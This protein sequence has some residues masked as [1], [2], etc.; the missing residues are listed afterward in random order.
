MVVTGA[1]MF[2]R[3]LRI[4]LFAAVAI[5]VF[6][7][8]GCQSSPGTAASSANN[9][10]VN[11]SNSNA[12]ADTAKTDAEEI[13]RLLDEYNTALLARDSETLARIWADDLNFVNPQGRVVTKSER[14][15]NIKAGAT[16]L[17]S[18]EVTDKKIQMYGSAAVGT[19]TVKI[20]GQYSAESGSG[21]YRVTTVWAK[22]KGNWQMV[23]SQMT[24][25]V[26]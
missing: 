1:F 3:S 4:S 25:I 20:N 13:S 2:H 23:S 8:V 17:R 12:N 22:P 24:L 11:S 15:E 19:L 21:D 10:T 18:A 16:N 26:E 5:C 14:V 9:T 6:A 7:G